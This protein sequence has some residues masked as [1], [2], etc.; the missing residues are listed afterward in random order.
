MKTILSK[1]VNEALLCG[2]RMMSEKSNVR[3]ISPRG[4]ETIECIEPVCTIYTHPRERVLFEPARD[5]NPFFH[6]MESLW[7]L[8]GRNDVEWIAQFNKNIATYS[9]NGETFHG[10]YG[11]R[12]RYVV[13]N[14][15]N[16]QDQLEEVVHLLKEDSNTRR[17]VLQI[18]NAGID[19]NVN[20]KDL[21]CNDLIFLK[22]RDDK[23]IMTVCNRSN[24]MIWGAYG[25]NAV[26]F[27]ILQ[28]YIAAKVGVEVGV[29]RQ[30]SDSYHVY[31]NNPQ[32]KVLREIYASPTD[33]IDCDWYTFPN[34]PRVKQFS[35]K[36]I[37]PFPLIRNSSLWDLELADFMSETDAIIDKCEMIKRTFN[38]PFFNCVAVHVF[39]TWKTYKHCR[40]H[41]APLAPAIKM[42]ENIAAIDWKIACV[43]WLERRGDIK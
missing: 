21:P 6:L 23:L 16:H 30:V 19:L 38:E 14:G 43:K 32:W 17:A 5:A 34:D 12:L 24:D 2:V 31:T 39:N 37:E 1:N 15:W 10:A 42:A 25:A 26:H 28:E 4:Q 29:Y 11:H 3:N 22:I 13:C 35:V 8:A 41:G 20:S 36:R 7:I 27:S 40:K 9:D 18:W 33:S